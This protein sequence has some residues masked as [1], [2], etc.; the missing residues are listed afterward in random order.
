MGISTAFITIFGL[1]SMMKRSLALTLVCISSVH[2]FTF[3]VSAV[4]KNEETNHLEDSGL[5]SGNL[6][7]FQ[8]LINQLQETLVKMTLGKSVHALMNDMVNLK[9]NM[10]TLEAT[11]QKTESEVTNLRQEVEALKRENQKLEVKNRKCEDTLNIVKQN[12]TQVNEHFQEFASQSEKK[13]ETFERNTSS[14][15]SDLKV[16]VRYLTITLFDLNEDML[17]VKTGTPKLI[18]ETFEVFSKGLNST[19]EIFNKNLIATSNRMSDLE[20]L[21]KVQMTTM[22]GKL[23]SV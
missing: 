18:D 13:R 9:Q 10:E 19:L 14:V 7:V 5:D 16:E 17:E 12:F 11:Q 3:S 4:S 20:N 21:Q 6:D 8:Q 2:L 15:L 1:A 22:F 23:Q